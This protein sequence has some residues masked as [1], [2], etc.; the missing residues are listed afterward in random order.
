MKKKSADHEFEEISSLIRDEEKAALN[1]FRSRD[2]RGSVMRKWREVRQDVTPRPKLR[3]MAVWASA[4][5]LPVVAVAVFFLVRQ[6]SVPE[7]QPDFRALASVLGALPGGVSL[8]REEPVGPGD[9]GP[10]DASSLAQSVRSALAVAETTMRL[11]EVR[12]SS[13]EPAAAV[14]RLSL[15][16]KMEILYKDRVIERALLALKDPSKEV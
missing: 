6:A 15:Y 11:E 1:D 14:T 4:A 5:A 12:A 10:L 2:F 8:S 9:P 16:K 7:L 3:R 13:P